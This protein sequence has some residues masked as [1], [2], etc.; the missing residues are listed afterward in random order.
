MTN[1]FNILDWKSQVLENTLK[2]HRVLR[3]PLVRFWCLNQVVAQGGNGL[4]LRRVSDDC[5][6]TIGFQAWSAIEAFKLRVR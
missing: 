1:R 3:V 5:F 6:R 4:A 2:A